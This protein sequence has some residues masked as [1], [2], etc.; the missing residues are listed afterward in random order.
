VSLI[1][2]TIAVVDKVI[3]SK[4]SEVEHQ[5]LIYVDVNLIIRKLLLQLNLKHFPKKFFEKAEDYSL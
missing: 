3:K 1:E 4:C 2:Q 5:V